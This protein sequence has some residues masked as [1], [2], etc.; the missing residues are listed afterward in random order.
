MGRGAHLPSR[1]HP[2]GC[3][4]CPR[5]SA[6]DAVHAFGRTCPLDGAAH[7]CGGPH[8]GQEE[9]SERLIGWMQL[10]LAAILA[11][12]YLIAPRPLDAQL[13]MQSTRYEPWHL[14]FQIRYCQTK[15]VN[16]CRRRSFGSLM[17]SNS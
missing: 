2:E 14:L 13:S 16:V 7:A 15:H 11:V 12:L 5:S 8:R 6:T 9:D 3:R 1:S 10:T 4:D 17:A